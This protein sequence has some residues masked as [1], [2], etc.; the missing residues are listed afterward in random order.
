MGDDGVIISSEFQ[1]NMEQFG[2]CHLVDDTFFNS[3]TYTELSNFV[4]YWFVLEIVLSPSHGK[5]NP[6]FEFFFQRVKF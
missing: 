3:I 6:A 2:A 5:I 4:L 1:Q